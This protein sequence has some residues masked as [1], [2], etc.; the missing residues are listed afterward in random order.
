MGE[1][2]SKISSRPVVSGTPASPAAFAASRRWRHDSLPTSQ[3]KLSVWSA[4]R[5]GTVRVSVILANES[6]EAVRPFLGVLDVDAVR[7]AAKENNLRETR[8]VSVRVGRWE[9]RPESLRSRAQYDGEGRGGRKE[10]L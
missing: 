10:Q 2:S 9:S 4:S 7:A 6:R 1:I 8:Q 5:S 3:S